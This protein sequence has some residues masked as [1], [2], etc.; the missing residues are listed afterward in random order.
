MLTPRGILIGIILLTIVF[1]LILVFRAQITREFGG[2]ILALTAILILPAIVGV[3]AFN[4][5]IDDSKKTE[6][7]L[8]CHDMQSR[9]RSLLVDDNEYIPAVHFQNNRIP[10]EQAC[11]TC[12]TQYTMFG[13]LSSKL[14]GLKHLYYEYIGTIPDT[15]K[16]AEKYNNRECLHCHDGARSFEENSAHR[17]TPLMIDSLKNNSISCITSGCHDVI[18]DV[19]NL[20]NLE[21]WERGRVK[22]APAHTAAKPADTSGGNEPEDTSSQEEEE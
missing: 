7:C 4:I 3:Y 2:K 12:H 11:Y 5:H 21:F 22:I 15:I 6:Y 8:S 20:A 14:R 18:H 16:I 10:Q 1:D 13:D 17:E 19:G 9:G